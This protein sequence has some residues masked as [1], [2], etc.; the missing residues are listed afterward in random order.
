MLHIFV[1]LRRLPSSGGCGLASRNRWM[2]L[3]AAMLII[4]GCGGG[5]GA[6]EPPSA[7]EVASAT[8]AVATLAAAPPATLAP[9]Q[10]G[11]AAATAPA[12]VVSSVVKFNTEDGATLSGTLFGTGKTVALLAHMRPTDQRS[13]QAFARKVAEAGYAA[14]T[15][16]FRGYGASGGSP[17]ENMRDKDARAAINYLRGRGFQSIILI[18]ASMGGSACA[19]N[20]HEANVTGLA[21]ISSSRNFAGVDVVE[22]D[23]NAPIAKLFIASQDDEP[24]ATDIRTM[25]AMASDPKEIA[26][27]TGN[28]HGTF[29]FD[30]EHKAELE[31]LLLDFIRKAAGA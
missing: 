12:Q 7:A 28:G 10:A 27:F 14:F 31:Q 26:L 23:L 17:Q 8:S 18:G 22:S 3:T 9:T 13:W 21:M 19:K 15:F 20:T 5:A 4:A 24:A 1:S 2:L 16:D 30:G 11:A 29:I 6:T 25:H